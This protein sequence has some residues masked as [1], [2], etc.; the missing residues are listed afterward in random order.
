MTDRKTTEKLVNAAAAFR[1]DPETMAQDYGATLITFI[2]VLAASVG[3]HPT[4]L[5]PLI[6]ATVIGLI[7]HRATIL[8]DPN[9]GWSENLLSWTVGLAYSSSGKSPAVAFINNSLRYAPIRTRTLLHIL[10]K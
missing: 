2:E 8:I 3:V 5:A 7:G 9:N 4:M 10:N 1:S 6:L